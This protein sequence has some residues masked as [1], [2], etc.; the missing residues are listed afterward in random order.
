ML[1]RSLLSRDK[2]GEVLPNSYVGRPGENTN[3]DVIDHVHGH[4]TVVRWRKWRYQA[5]RVRQ[6]FWTIMCHVGGGE[7]GSIFQSVTRDVILRER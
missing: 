4:P 5:V 1:V 2:Y 3:I 7:V 6:E